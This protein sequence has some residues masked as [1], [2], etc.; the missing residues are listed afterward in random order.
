MI[1]KLSNEQEELFEQVN[2]SWRTRIYNYSIDD[3]ENDCLRFITRFTEAAE[4][5]EPIVIFLESP[6]ACLLTS[7]TIKKINTKELCNTFSIRSA[8]NETWEEIALMNQ[9]FNVSDLYSSPRENMRETILELLEKCKWKKDFD[10]TNSN[11]GDIFHNFFLSRNIEEIKRKI[12]HHVWGL[13]FPQGYAYGG[14]FMTISLN[15]VTDCHGNSLPW[16]YDVFIFYDFM[17]RLG[18]I[19]DSLFN[20]IQ[21]LLLNGV[22]DFFWSGQFCFVSKLPKTVLRNKNGKLHSFEGYP[23]VEFSD[24][25][26]LYYKKG[27][28]I[29]MGQSLSM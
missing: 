24:G 10:E 14:D 3:Y 19:Q 22:Y 13:Y 2:R 15:L 7:I 5:K 6:L 23:A 29:T 1:S 9:C 18:I 8:I 16:N 12:S 28:R 17:S 20:S 21:S 27:K 25:Y 11:G 4:V 26:K